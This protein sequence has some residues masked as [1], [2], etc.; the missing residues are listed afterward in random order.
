M[1]NAKSV[2]N[3]NISNL[4]SLNNLDAPDFV[5]QFTL[6]RM[7]LAVATVLFAYLLVLFS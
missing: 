5:S 1:L 6:V 4:A 3:A 2:S 7:E